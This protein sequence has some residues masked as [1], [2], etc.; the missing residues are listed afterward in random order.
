MRLISI[1][2]GKVAPL[3]GDHHP[4][5]KTVASA[6]RK[7]P[8][9]DLDNSV[10]VEITRLGVKGDEQAELKKPSMPI[11][12]STMLSGMNC[13]HEKPKKQCNF[14]TVLSEKISRLKAC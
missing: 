6:I 12:L 2:A 7:H 5:Y 14:N 8:L 10:P 13:S 3:L 9:S 1:S 11:L 4:N